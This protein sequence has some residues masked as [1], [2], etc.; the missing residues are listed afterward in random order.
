M[1]YN[2]TFDAS[3]DTECYNVRGDGNLRGAPPR[4]LNNPYASNLEPS[5]KGVNISGISFKQS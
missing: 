3:E 2:A 4:V 5:I 1:N